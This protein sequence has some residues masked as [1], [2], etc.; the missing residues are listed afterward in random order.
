M[1]ETVN[2]PVSS[3]NTPPESAF[4]GQQYAQPVYSQ[5]VI[6]VDA[7]D[8]IPLE[9]V[10]A[11]VGNDSIV[12]KFIRMEK[13]G[14]KIS[15]CWPAA[16]LGFI[17][18]PA[19]SAVWFFRRK[20]C[21]KAVLLLAVGVLM[22]TANAALGALTYSA[23]DSSDLTTIINGVMDGSIGFAEYMT[24]LF[25]WAYGGYTLPYILLGL[26]GNMMNTATGV[27]CG[28]FG[29]YAYKKHT[30]SRIRRYRTVNV[31]PRYYQLGLSALG[32][33][34]GGLM[35]LGIIGLWVM[36]LV[37]QMVSHVLG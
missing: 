4:A 30:V 34:S 29:D 2:G 31:D 32:G 22:F 37:A 12:S 21:K 36:F 7:V 17:L 1:N 28:L 19:G 9:D 6:E 25:E 18:G 27:L 10:R 23:P 24:S 8:G 11:F 26:L 13:T 35:T 15:W 14:S 3:V 33:T 16:V 20:M 5:P